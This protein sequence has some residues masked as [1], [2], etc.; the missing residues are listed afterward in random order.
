MTTPSAF[1][2][3]TSGCVPFN[4]TFDDLANGLSDQ[5]AWHDLSPFAQGYVE[6]L[7]AS[8]VWGQT[9]KHCAGNGEIIT[10]WDRYLGAPK[11]GDRG[12]EGTADCPDCDGKGSRSVAFRDIAPET[13]ARIIADCEAMQGHGLAGTVSV[14][15]GAWDARQSSLC[16][17]SFPPLTVTLGDDGK[18]RFA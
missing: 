11:P 15:R 4:P 9:C 14:G 12:D 16:V 17:P 1:T 10:D 5:V 8:G 7:F 6:A 2:L 13:L 18:V 3:D